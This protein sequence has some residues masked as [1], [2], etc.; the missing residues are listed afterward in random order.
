ME[1]RTSPAKQ[2]PPRR[3]RPHGG[4]SPLSAVRKTRR[5]ERHDHR[6]RLI[7]G[8]AAAILGTLALTILVLNLSSGERSIDH[9][10]AHIYGVGDPQFARSMGN[11]LGPPLL[12]GNQEWLQRPWKERVLESA[13]AVFRSQI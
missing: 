10:V 3:T 4:G 9:R 13:A 12:P 6:R 1:T 2:R 11:L 7:W 5:H 8:I